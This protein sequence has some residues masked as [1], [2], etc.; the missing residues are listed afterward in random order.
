V[1][2][3]LVGVLV[4]MHDDEEMGLQVACWHG[5]EEGMVRQPGGHCHAEE[6]EVGEEHILEHPLAMQGVDQNGVRCGDGERFGVTQRWGYQAER[7]W[8]HETA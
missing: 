3:W 7:D 4:K 1:G 6:I 8:R 2:R 5:R